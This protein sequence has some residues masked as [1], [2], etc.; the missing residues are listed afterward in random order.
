MAAAAVAA[1]RWLRVFWAVEGVSLTDDAADEEVE[2][3]D[4]EED[5]EDDEDNDEAGAGGADELPSA[6]CPAAEVLGGGGEAI[7][8]PG[9]LGVLDGP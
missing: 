1:R 4:A 2:E 8:A 6:W 9:V 3:E 5:D 7:A